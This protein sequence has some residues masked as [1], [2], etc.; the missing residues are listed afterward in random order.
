MQSTSVTVLGR[1]LAKLPDK[2]NAGIAHTVELLA[3]TPAE[4]IANSVIALALR[5]KYPAAAKAAL[6]GNISDSKRLAENAKVFDSLPPLSVDVSGRDEEVPGS[7]KA[8]AVPIDEFGRITFAN[9]EKKFGFLTNEVTGETLFFLFRYVSDHALLDDIESGTVGHKVHFVVKPVIKSPRARFDEARSIRLRPNQNALVI[10]ARAPYATR[11]DARPAKPTW[12][13]KAAG[14]YADAKRFEQMGNFKAAEELL[15]KAIQEGGR[16]RQSAIKD[17]AMLMGRGNRAA[18]GIELLDRYRDEFEPKRPVD[19]LKATLLVKLGEYRKAAK[20][21]EELYRTAPS[22]T[23][24]A[25]GAAKQAGY[26]YSLLSNFEDALKSFRA[27]KAISPS[28]STITDAI[29]RIRRAKSLGTLSAEDTKQLQDL[30]GAAVASG[31]SSFAN[32]FMQ[33]SDFKGA[34]ERSIARGFFETSDFQKIDRQLR[35]IRGRQPRMKGQLYQTLAAMSVKTPLES[36]DVSVQDALRSCFF[37]MGEAALND[38]LA[39][40]SVRCFL[41]EA[42]HIASRPDQV[43]DVARYLL[44]TYLSEPLSIEELS[45]DTRRGAVHLPLQTVIKLF[46]GDEAGWKNLMSDLPYYASVAEYAVILIQAEARRNPVLGQSFFLEKEL[47]DL[48]RK[49]VERIQSELNIL[50]PLLSQ[51]VTGDGLQQ[52][53]AT[54]SSSA[55]STRFKLDQVRLYELGKLASESSTYWREQDYIEREATYGRVTGGLKAL[56]DAIK[57]EPTK[58]TIEMILPL[59]DRLLLEILDDFDKFRTGASAS[60]SLNNLLKDDYYV[61]DLDGVITLA[62]ELNSERGS[63]PI[64]GVSLTV[65]SSEKSFQQIEACYSPELLRGGGRREIQV[66]IKPSE[67]QLAE[68]AFTI[69][70]TAR[71]HN[72]AANKIEDTVFSLPIAIGASDSFSDL[73]NPYAAY[74]G[75]AIVNDPKM[76]FGRGEL[77]ARIQKQVVE[78]PVGQCFVLYGQKRSGKSSVLYRLKETLVRPQ[79]GVLVTVG[80]MDIYEAEV[81][82][83]RQCI[84][85]IQEQLTIEVPAFS[86]TAPTYEE[87]K[88][89]PLRTFQLFLR[90]TLGALSRAGWDEPRLVLLIDEFTYLFE[91][92]QEKIIPRSFMRQWKAL[93][94]L[95]LFSAVVVGQDSMPKFKQSFPNEFGV[96]HDER[97]SYLSPTDAID[98]AQRPIATAS[99]GRYR[100][101]AMEKLLE[102]T[103]GSPFYLQIMCDHLVRHL[104]RRRRPFL[105]EADVDQVSIEL[106]TGANFL[107]IERFDPLITAAGESVAEASRDTYLQLLTG[108]AHASRPSGAARLEDMPTI[109][110]RT[111]LLKDLRERDVLLIDASGRYAISSGIVC[112]MAAGKRAVALK[113]DQLEMDNPFAGYGKVIRGERLVGRTAALDE[114]S[115]RISKNGG[116]VAII[117]SPRIGKTSLANEIMHRSTDTDLRLVKIWVDLSTVPGSVELF[118]SIT[119]AAASG[120]A[121]KDQKTFNLIESI[122][123]SSV[124]GSY[125]AYRATRRLLSVAATAGFAFQLFVDEFDWIRKYHDSQ[126][127]IQRLRDLIY[128]NFETELSAVFIARRSLRAIESTISDVS[129]LDGVCEQHYLGPLDV[130]GFRELIARAATNGWSMAQ[131]QVD[132]LE[133]Y[134]G[135]HPY[136]AEMILCRAWLQQS[137]LEGA[138]RAL[139]RNF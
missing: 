130:E 8:S 46:E 74:S 43:T 124:N 55:V 63:T 57:K 49:E 97:I 90:D 36:G 44:N 7:P 38:K 92:I 41:A 26:C 47:E 58:L 118:Q 102:C 31:L 42:A 128:R 29:E 105:T 99:G 86:T 14:T 71:Y 3:G 16:Y 10:K 136:L 135:G 85:A 22:E 73:S 123:K 104:N 20:L 28:D 81:S 19:N 1:L 25:V 96:T 30:A 48:R 32:F 139:E 94:E 79:L 4:S 108:I 77:L 24:D 98:L 70:V 27:A 21:Y 112:R 60:L 13:P 40:D 65:T 134:T 122:A 52:I 115:E 127:A 113:L 133:Y 6:A 126:I 103:A 66:R 119:E 33:M 91:Y 117:G 56:S 83:V 54:L 76:L 114:I 116:S 59:A 35:A 87:I 109:E 62:L 93:L 138:S 18:E 100:G 120:I 88:A 15:P 84:D 11:T 39:S 17:L 75:G 89:S 45:T 106:T 34:D 23:K 67:S 80:T 61:P 53:S 121:I 137:V 110:N 125:E 131:D 129:T 51:N 50:R 95:G 68:L 72:R 12:L 69:Q 37:F 2:D 78:G 5:A 111:L 9:A 82:F 64:E 107:P 132:L 101:R